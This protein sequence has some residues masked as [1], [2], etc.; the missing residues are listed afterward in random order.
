MKKMNRFVFLRMG[1]TRS[2]PLFS[3]YNIIMVGYLFLKETGFHW[4]FF[5]A[6]TFFVFW[7]W[8]DMKCIWPREVDA[9]FGK[10]KDMME[11]LKIVKSLREGHERG[12]GTKK[13]PK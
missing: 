10:S 11:V 6:P 2:L 7:V 13:Q 3:L 5:L 9:V 4:E 1:V 8:F 12:R